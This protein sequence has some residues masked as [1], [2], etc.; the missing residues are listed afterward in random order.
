MQKTKRNIR[1]K[2]AKFTGKSLFIVTVI[3]VS[4]LLSIF[5]GQLGTA[6]FYIVVFITLWAKRWDWKYFGMTK[7]DWPKTIFKAFLFTM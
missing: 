5:A 4:L 1:E 3:I 7:P 6:L 2:V